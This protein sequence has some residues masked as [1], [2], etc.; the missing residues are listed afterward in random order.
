MI[1]EVASGLAQITE[2]LTSNY[3]IYPRNDP[4]TIEMVCELGLT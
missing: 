4:L 3:F 1:P 2:W